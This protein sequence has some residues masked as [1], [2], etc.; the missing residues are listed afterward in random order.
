MMNKSTQSGFTLIELILSMVLLGIV[1]VTAGMLIYQAARSFEAL[2]DQKE[3]TQQ[4]TL[5]LER[6]SRELRP[7]KCTAS[8]NSCNASASD[9]PVMTASELRFLNSSYEGRGLRLS[10]STLLLRDGTGDSD[11]EYALATGVSSLTFEYLK[12]DGTAAASAAELW[13]VSMN[14]AIASGQATIAVK[15]SVHPR[16]FR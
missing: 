3:V 15:A 8:G 1:A 6:V 14:M 11:P 16:G 10:G 9:V 2:S 7:M 12:S 13:T 5:A 4:S